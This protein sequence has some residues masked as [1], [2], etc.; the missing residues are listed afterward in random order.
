MEGEFVGNAEFPSFVFH[1]DVITA[2]DGKPEAERLRAELRLGPF[3]GLATQFSV[4]ILQAIRK[5]APVWRLD[6]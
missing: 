5:Q 6:T 2:E 4:V 1:G 3:L